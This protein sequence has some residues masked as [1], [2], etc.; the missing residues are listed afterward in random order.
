[1]SSSNLENC[2]MDLLLC[3]RQADPLLTGDARAALRAGRGGFL[4]SA[5]AASTAGFTGDDQSVASMLGG[6]DASS[7]GRADPQEVLDRR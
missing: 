7:V 2:R 3:K 5:G 1:V 4:D 6:F